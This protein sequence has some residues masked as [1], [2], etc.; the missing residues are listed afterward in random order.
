MLEE[1]KPNE[2]VKLIKN[3]EFFKPIHADLDGMLRP[4]LYIGRSPQLVDKFCGPHGKLTKALEPYQAAIQAT[5]AAEL[6]V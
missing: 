3:S 5:K 1:G 4:E 6:H 2:L